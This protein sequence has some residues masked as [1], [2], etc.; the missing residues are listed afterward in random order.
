MQVK[1]SSKIE[2]LKLYETIHESFYRF[3][4]AISGSR[5][6]AE[7]LVNDSLLNVLE[8]FDKIR[9]KSAFKSYLFSVASNLNK[10]K[11]RRSKFKV[12]L[13]EEETSQ[14]TDKTQD[15]EYIVDFK[16]IYEKILTLPERTAEAIILYHISDLSLEEIRQI[17]G[18]SLSGVKLR[19]KRGREKLLEQL[20]TPAQVRLALM[21]LTL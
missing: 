3:C 19:L 11:Q 18:G 4:R 9:D 17:Q 14:I 21:L 10:M 7:D 1:N 20:N 16:I 15:P 12:Q 5:E 2:F 13:D 6:D 8:S